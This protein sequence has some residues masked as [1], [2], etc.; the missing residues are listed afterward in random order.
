MNRSML[1]AASV[2][3]VPSFVGSS[4]VMVCDQSWGFVVSLGC[5]VVR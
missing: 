3:R 1:N 5:F 2:A 4:C